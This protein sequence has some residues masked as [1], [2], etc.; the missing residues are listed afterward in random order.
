ML[1][2][3]RAASWLAASVLVCGPAAWA[4]QSLAPLLACR[5]IADPAARLACFDRETATLAAHEATAG[6]PAEPPVTR[7]A[8]PSEP[9]AGSTAEATQNFGLAPGAIA[10]KEVARGKRPA[11]LSRIQAHVAGLSRAGDGRFVFTLDNGQIW[12]QVLDEGDL[13]LRPGNA[14]TISHGLLHSFILHA[15]SGRGCK[16]TRIR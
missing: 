14:V 3:W 9:A 8:V 11:D 5:G 6:I 12:L 1:G 2:K 7:S 15:P 10:A 13:L 4:S 16:V